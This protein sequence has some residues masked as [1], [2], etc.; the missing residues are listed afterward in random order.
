MPRGAPALDYAFCLQKAMQARANYR[1]ASTLREYE[2]WTY[3]EAK[4]IDLANF[5]RS[6][7]DVRISDADLWIT[8]YPTCPHCT[9]LMRL[10][11]IEPADP[12]YD[13]RVFICACGHVEDI[14]V[15]IELDPV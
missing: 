12:G 10:S 1:K 5:Y 2:F 11:F 6:D 3:A 9:G 14:K 8:T 7:N 4:W 13:R 15:R